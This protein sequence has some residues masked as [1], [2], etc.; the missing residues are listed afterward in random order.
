[1]LSAV[2]T[3]FNANVFARFASTKYFTKTHEFIDVDDKVGK[4]GI[5]QYAA[6]HLGEIVYAE[7]PEIDAE[8]MKDEVLC[9]VESVKAASDVVMPVG[10]VV[11]G[12]NS[13]LESRP[14][15]I[16]ENPFNGW[17]AEVQ[18]SDLEELNGLMTQADYQEYLQHCDH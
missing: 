7:L 2:R 4:V 1:M 12:V 18:I 15:M 17:I 8:V 10:G 14:A 3:S 11:T 9:A 5:T 6:T 16:N 13:E